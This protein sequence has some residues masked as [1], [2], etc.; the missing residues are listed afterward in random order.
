MKNTFRLMIA[1]FAALILSICAVSAQTKKPVTYY[2]G[3]EPVTAPST[4]TTAYKPVDRRTLPAPWDARSRA[5]KELMVELNQRG[6]PQAMTIVACFD[7]A[8]Q[9]FIRIAVILYEGGNSI[10]NKITEGKL[11]AQFGG[12]LWEASRDTRSRILRADCDAVYFQFSNWK[13]TF[14]EGPYPVLNWMGNHQTAVFID[15]VDENGGRAY[16]FP[17]TL[18]D[19]YRGQIMLAIPKIL[20]QEWAQNPI[21]RVDVFDN[22]KLVESQTLPIGAKAFFT[23]PENGKWKN[24]FDRAIGEGTDLLR[25]AYVV[26][27]GVCRRTFDY[28][29][30]M[31]KVRRKAQGG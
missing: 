26:K 1:A 25:L 22:G 6:C 31:D 28:A 18:T 13:R 4:P 17:Q 16:G 29:A 2:G 20:V 27:K 24:D 10:I 14:P 7:E 8:P 30:H 15:T 19:T 5:T 12:K 21:L 23:I 3:S 9:L 11:P